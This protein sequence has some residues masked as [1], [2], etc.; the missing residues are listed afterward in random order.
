MKR[1]LL[2]LLS[3]ALL[4]LSCEKDPEVLDVPVASVT[5]DKTELYLIVGD[6]Y[7]LTAT[8]LPEDASDK[9][10][11]WS[12]KDASVA[13]VTPSGVVK[14]LKTGKTVVVAR[15]GDQES[16]CSLSVDETVMLSIG[17]FST[18]AP[19]Y[20]WSGGDV[21]VSVTSNN[22]WKLNSD[23]SW[24]TATPS[25][26]SAG[27]TEVTIS[28]TENTT[29]SN[30][31]ATLSTSMGASGTSL[32]VLQRASIYTKT[33]AA[34]GTVTNA[35]KVTYSK[36]EL[37]RTVGLIP[38]PTSNMYQEITD[39]YTPNGTVK[40]CPDGINHYLIT[41][42]EGSGVP[43]SG[44]YIVSERFYAKTYNYTVALSRITDIAA[45]DPE[46]PECKKYLGAEN[47][48]Y[49]DPSHTEI[50]SVADQ[51]WTQSGGDIL[52]YAEA[53]HNWTAQHL[54]YGNAYTGLHT[55]AEIMKTKKCDCA[56]FSSVF[57][58]LLRNK[59]IPARHIVMI[60]PDKHDYHVRAEFYLP[61][62][63][64]IPC[65]PTFQN[66]NPQGNFFGNHTG[67][68]V[69]MSLGINAR[70]ENANGGAMTTPLL[71]TY[72]YWYWYSKSGSFYFTHDFTPF[73]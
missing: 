32:K 16:S 56:N 37:T 64:W 12:T 42:L 66:G 31:E 60:E 73:K 39:F 63:G 19:I 10:V 7:T 43:T 61:A 38:V 49:V 71:Q 21:T 29:Q 70:C 26:G 35:V 41:N 51:L 46:S 25:S 57:I 33:M 47:D 30:R 3:C 52:K 1:Y 55:I 23:A 27:V 18:D 34:S 48:G 72:W 53:C 17:S 62:Y 67:K 28:T 22:D 69:V 8:V 20:K 58:S 9:S 15:A 45:Y 5:L 65:D 54:T 50:A 59:S 4:V 40:D 44:G 36:G 11:S 68:Y 24:L 14:A 13:E 6:T 2:P